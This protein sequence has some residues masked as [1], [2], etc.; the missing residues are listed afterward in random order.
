M[1]TESSV[2]ND[3]IYKLDILLLKDRYFRLDRLLNI[4]K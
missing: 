1:Y 4:Y 2:A 3:N